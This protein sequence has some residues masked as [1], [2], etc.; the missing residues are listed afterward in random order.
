MAARL[1]PDLPPRRDGDLTHKYH[2]PSRS[3]SPHR[4]QPRR[5]TCRFGPHNARSGASWRVS[6][7][8]LR[9][10]PRIRGHDAEVAA[11]SPPSSSGLPLRL[12]V[13]N[14]RDLA[15]KTNRKIERGARRQ[16]GRRVACRFSQCANR[17]GYRPDCR[18][19]RLSTY[20]VRARDPRRRCVPAVVG[21]LAVAPVS[22]PTTPPSI[23]PIC[24]EPTRLGPAAR[25]RPFPAASH[26]QARTR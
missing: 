3:G 26:P 5:L 1:E 11:S 19:T 2:V 4:P 24:R 23:V 25:A 21:E 12:P 9:M 22:I 14:M 7:V 8:P 13:Q 17:S 6:R 16:N 15:Q 20:R 18:F 10:P